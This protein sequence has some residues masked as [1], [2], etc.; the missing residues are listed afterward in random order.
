MK[1]FLFITP[2]ILMFILFAGCRPARVV[3]HE[4]PA[5][6]RFVQPLAPGPNYVWHS[7]EWIR[8]GNTY[9]YHKGF[10]IKAPT[11]RRY[12]VAGHWQRRRGGWIWIPGHWR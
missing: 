6:P 4:R 8:H 3:V 5:E 11:K 12:Y 10:W 1:K 9:V 2:L 7:G